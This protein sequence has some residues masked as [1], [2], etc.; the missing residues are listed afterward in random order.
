LTLDCFIAATALIVAA[1][2]P[3]MGEQ[4]VTMG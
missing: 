2:A 1:G 4:I 3:E